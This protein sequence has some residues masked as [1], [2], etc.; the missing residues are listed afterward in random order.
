MSHR[1]SFNDA[2]EHKPTLNLQYV[3]LFTNSATF[4]QS[5]FNQRDREG[6]PLPN[7]V[8]AHMRLMGEE[9]SKIV[10]EHGLER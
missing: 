6:K 3:E 1:E 7:L 4:K 10:K 9:R 8:Q 5:F 2:A